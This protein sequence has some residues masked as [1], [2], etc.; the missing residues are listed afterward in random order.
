MGFEGARVPAD[1]HFITPIRPGIALGLLFGPGKG[2]FT[3]SPTLLLSLVGL[4]LMARRRPF[5][6]LGFFLVFL[7]TSLFYSKLGWFPDGSICWAS[8]YHIHLIGLLVAPTMVAIDKLWHRMSGKAAV[9]V[10]IALSIVFQILSLLALPAL[11]YQ[12]IK[13]DKPVFPL[14]MDPIHGQLALRATTTAQLLMGRPDTPGTA[15]R[16]ESFDY[17]R[18]AIPVFWGPT[19]ARRIGGPAIKAAILAIWVASLLLGL[20]MVFHAL[21]ILSKPAISDHEDSQGPIDARPKV[22]LPNSGPS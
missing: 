16:G 17:H 5:L 20:A 1:S 18:N 13:R 15:F 3:T 22:G 12:Q 6:I 10:I 9:I 2:F 21:R 7:V 4:V 14:I 19:Y 8:R 11:E